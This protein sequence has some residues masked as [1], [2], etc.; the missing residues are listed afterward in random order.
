MA[1]SQAG[2]GAKM[3]AHKEE[4]RGHSATKPL[5]S[6]LSSSLVKYP[7]VHDAGNFYFGC[8]HVHTPCA[9]L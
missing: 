8:V 6:V 4:R 9:S 1:V 5:L 7:V 3:E 2:R